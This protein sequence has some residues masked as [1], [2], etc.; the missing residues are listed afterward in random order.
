MPGILSHYLND[1]VEELRRPI[2]ARVLALIGEGGDQ[3][4]M[5]LLL[6]CGLFVSVKGQAENYWQISGRRAP[7]LALIIV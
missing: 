2:W 6:D 1:G 3:I 7:F 5:D 4:M